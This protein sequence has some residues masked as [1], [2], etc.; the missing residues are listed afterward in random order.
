MSMS[1]WK[2]PLP[3]RGVEAS[4]QEAIQRGEF[5]NLRGKGRPLNLYAYFDTPE[6]VRL[7]YSLLKD[8]GFIPEEVELRNE[9]VALS[10]ILRTEVDEAKRGRLRK[11]LR[12]RE[13]RLELLVERFHR[14][15][16]S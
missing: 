16:G 8:A 6:A 13:L 14:R 5:D 9:V 3:V 7:G 12:D 4:L 1:M 11:N 10:E 15:N 2:E